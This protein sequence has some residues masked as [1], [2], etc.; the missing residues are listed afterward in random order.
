MCVMLDNMLNQELLRDIHINLQFGELIQWPPF[1]SMVNCVHTCTHYKNK[2]GVCR[3]QWTGISVERVEKVDTH[4][5]F[6]SHYVT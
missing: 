3:C 6:H 2:F 4:A 5:L 1:S